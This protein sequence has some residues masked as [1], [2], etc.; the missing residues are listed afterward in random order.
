MTGSFWSYRMM[1]DHRSNF[2]MMDLS[3]FMKIEGIE[4]LTSD[5]MEQYQI[6][7][8]EINPFVTEKKGL[9][10]KVYVDFVKPSGKI[11]ILSVTPKTNSPN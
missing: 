7:P 1:F 10:W 3:E 11:E 4:R 8:D 9:K 6:V 2:E 5:S